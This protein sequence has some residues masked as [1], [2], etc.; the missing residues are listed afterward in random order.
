[1]KQ[2]TPSAAALPP[3][4]LRHPGRWLWLLL[5]VPAIIGLS[6]LRFDVEI[7]DLLPPDIPAVKG[8]KIY[9]EHFANAQ[10]LIIAVKSTRAEEAETAARTL[11]DHLRPHTNLV[12]RGTWEPPWLEHPDQA[13][14]LI[15]YLWFNQLPETFKELRARIAPEKLN[16]TLQNTREALATS[17][18][19]REIA[20]LSYD[21]FGL[22]QL[23][24]SAA[25]SASSFAQGQE[26]FGS[27]DGTFRIVFVQARP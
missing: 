2:S 9:Q 6:R 22:T 3:P 16:A 10:E 15:A 21:P 23:P 1:M 24:E 12:T 17:L 8:L 18:S 11:A 14:E 19:P 25:G 4:S 20:R 26:M 5:L 7:F 27:K 13:A